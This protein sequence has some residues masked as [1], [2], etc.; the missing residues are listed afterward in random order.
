MPLKDKVKVNLLQPRTKPLWDG[1]ES[2]T[3]Q[4]GVTFSLLSRFLVDRERF[5]VMVVNGLGVK[6]G[7]N[8]KLEFGNLWHCAEEWRE[9]DWQ[10]AIRAYAQ[11]LCKKYPTSVQ[12]VDRWYKL[13]KAVFPI[14]VE[15]WEKRKDRTKRT[16]VFT[17]RKFRVPYTLPSG[18]TVYLRGKWDGVDV[19]EEKGKK[20]LWNQENKT[21]SRIDQ[22]Q[23]ERQLNMDLQ[24][25]IYLIG[26]S[27]DTGIEELESIKGWNGKKFAVPVAGVRYN[28]VRRSEHRV[29]KKETVDGFV[30]RVAEQV[31]EEATEW[32]MRWDVTVPTSDI[33][34]FCHRSLNPILEGLCDWWNWVNRGT[35]PFDN[36]TDTNSARE[37]LGHNSIHFQMP[38]GVWNPLLE[39]APTDLDEYL[40]TGSTVGLEQ[41]TDLFPELR[42]E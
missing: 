38:Y 3:D 12:D 16:N 20:T 40:R 30:Q 41:K 1:P 36:Y 10:S 28:V 6:E 5:R 24:T 9:G 17:E 27:H 33:E 31:A 37:L 29:G 15:F 13:C 14:Y 21:K 25:M 8:H 4:G 2:N 26:L 22:F 19:V 23:I 18:R 32:F 34:R 7:F 35:D 11:G 42:E 39:G